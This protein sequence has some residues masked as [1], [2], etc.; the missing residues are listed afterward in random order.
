MQ[1]QSL[2]EKMAGL[3]DN[4][5]DRPLSEA[6]AE[7]KAALNLQLEELIKREEISRRQKS[8]ALWLK[9][10]DRNTSSSRELPM[11]I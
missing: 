1:R 10:G 5:E 3:D 11:P 6:E 8:R 4:L 2:Q 9:E 7:E